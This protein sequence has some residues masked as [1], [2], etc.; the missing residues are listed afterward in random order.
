MNRGYTA[1]H[2]ASLVRRIRETLS[3][4]SLTTDILTGFPGETEDDFVETLGAMEAIGFDDA[5][6]YYYN[7]REGTPAFSMPDALP[8]DVKLERLSRVIEAQ[9]SI[10]R[11]RA[12][13][14]IGREVE[15]LVEGVSKKEKGELLARTE[16][17]AMVVFRGELSRIGKFSRVR[18]ASL[19]G[20]TFKGEAV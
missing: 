17:D 15:V 12:I 11:R 5:F 19:A 3:G 16:W 1:E 14:R 18:L 4:V 6:M 13:E 20:S 7:P 9:R 10:G 8:D 2:Y